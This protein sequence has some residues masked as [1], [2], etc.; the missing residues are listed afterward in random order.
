MPEQIGI[1]EILSEEEDNEHKDEKDEK[2][3]KKFLEE[4]E[5]LRVSIIKDAFIQRGLEKK[6]NKEGCCGFCTCITHDGCFAP[7]CKKIS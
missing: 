5:K 1:K 2:K 6:Q 7:V 3:I 4:K